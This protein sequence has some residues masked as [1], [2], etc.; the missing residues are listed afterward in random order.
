MAQ[1]SKQAGAEIEITP[2][3]VEEAL[4]EIRTWDHGLGF[5]AVELVRRLR[6]LFIHGNASFLVNGESSETSA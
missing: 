6:F 3:M 1:D 4:F 2:E 5:S